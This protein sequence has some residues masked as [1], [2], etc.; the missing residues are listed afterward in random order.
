[1]RSAVK[2][3]FSFTRTL[4]FPGSVLALKHLQIAAQVITPIRVNLKARYEFIK[5]NINNGYLLIQLFGNNSNSSD[6]L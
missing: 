6:Y 4:T 5:C 3:L 2:V 1:M